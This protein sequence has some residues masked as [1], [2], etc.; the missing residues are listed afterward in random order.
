MP[1]AMF[2]LNWNSAARLEWEI[3]APLPQSYTPPNSHLKTRTSWPAAGFILLFVI[4][5]PIAHAQ[6][7]SEPLQTDDRA[8]PLEFGVSDI[9]GKVAYMG[10]GMNSEE[11]HNFDGS[12]TF[13]I[14]K[15]SGL[16]ADALYS[17]ISNEDFYG[18]A[19]H[20]QK[21]IHDPAQRSWVTFNERPMPSQLPC[22]RDHACPAH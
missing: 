2:K 9:N 1:I 3:A 19:G 15:Q 13:P 6:G 10:G 5:T 4:F 11:G 21:L 14:S 16:Q 8:D 7:D 22:R 20:L 17:R 12:I 18:A